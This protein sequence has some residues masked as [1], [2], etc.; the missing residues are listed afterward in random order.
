MGP[1]EMAWNIKSHKAFMITSYDS[2]KNLLHMWHS[3]IKHV[4][5]II[6]NDCKKMFINEF[7]ENLCWAEGLPSGSPY[8]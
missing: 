2:F 7:I 4:S 5:A 6:V 3:K 1:G 8:S